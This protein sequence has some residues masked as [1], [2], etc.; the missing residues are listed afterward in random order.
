ME[1][2]YLVE[3]EARYEYTDPQSGERCVLNVPQEMEQ[4]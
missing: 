4:W 3:A 2:N 1:N